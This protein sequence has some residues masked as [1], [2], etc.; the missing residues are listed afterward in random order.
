MA[1]GRWQLSVG[2]GISS[3]LEIN[4][5]RNPDERRSRSKLAGAEI[6]GQVSLGCCLEEESPLGKAAIC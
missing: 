5:N 2:G 6:A 1:G 3:D 4:F